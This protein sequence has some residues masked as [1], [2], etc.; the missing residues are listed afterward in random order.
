MVF[1]AFGCEDMEE[2]TSFGSDFYPLAVGNTW[3]YQID[4]IR[5][6]DFTNEPEEYTYFRQEVI[7]EEFATKTGNKRYSVDVS[8]RT[9]STDWVYHHS[10]V[11][12]KTEYRAV[13]SADNRE[14]MHLLFPIKNRVSWDGNL[15]NN[16]G[17]DRFRYMNAEK[18]MATLTDSFTNTVFVQ[19][20]L[21]TGVIYRDVRWELYAEGIGLVEKNSELTETQKDKTDGFHYHWKLISF[22]K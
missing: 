11:S 21:D 14:V 6:N 8:F 1:L 13:R 4:S 19:Q 2:P 18:P 7:V 15:L 9:D 10:E 17:E 3:V 12:Y 20:E 22:T 5:Y 16:S